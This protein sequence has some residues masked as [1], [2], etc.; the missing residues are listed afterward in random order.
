[1]ISFFG[2]NACVWGGLDMCVDEMCALKTNPSYPSSELY[3]DYYLREY[4]L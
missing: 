1:M 2:L 3:D 4:L